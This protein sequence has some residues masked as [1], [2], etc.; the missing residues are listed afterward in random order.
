MLSFALASKNYEKVNVLIRYFCIEG[1]YFIE[2]MRLFSLVFNGGNSA[3]SF[4]SL[5]SNQ[6]Y[7]GRILEKVMKT[8]K[9]NVNQYSDQDYAHILTTYANWSFVSRTY[10]VALQY[11]LMAK[12]LY[13]ESI[14]VN[15]YVAITFFHRASHKLESRHLHVLKV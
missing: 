11:Y 5:S 13:P 4:Y 15:L 1:P 7:L 3:L 8:R 2:G 14:E 9:D 10:P 6:K 12:S